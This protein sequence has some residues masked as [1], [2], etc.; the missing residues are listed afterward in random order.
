[1]TKFGKVEK[2]RRS[3]LLNRSIRFC[4]FQNKTEEGVK[5]E[6]LKIQDVLKQENGLKDIKRPR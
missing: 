6:D 3:G 4:Q 1:M 2:I 5:I